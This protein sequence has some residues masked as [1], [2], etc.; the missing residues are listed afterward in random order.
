MHDPSHLYGNITLGEPE[1]F[2]FRATSTE[3][4]IIL[5]TALASEIGTWNELDYYTSRACMTKIMT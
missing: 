5:S 1:L 3:N 2:S 4:P